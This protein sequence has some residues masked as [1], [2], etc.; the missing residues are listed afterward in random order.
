MNSSMQNR[1]KVQAKNRQSWIRAML[2]ALFALTLAT[3]GAQAT[4]ISKTNNTAGSADGG[5]IT[6][7]VTIEASDF[8][9]NSII[10]DV[11]VAVS[12]EKINGACPTHTDG[13]A[14]NNEI[15]FY[16]E[17]PTGTQ[18]VLV[19]DYL[20][21]AGSGNGATYTEHEYSGPVAVTFN[22]E[23]ALGI[24]SETP[25]SGSFKP[26]QLLS[27]FDDEDPVGDWTLYVGDGVP[28][29][30]LCFQ[31]FTLT[32]SAVQ[33]PVM[34]D[35][36]FDVV[37]HSPNGA[38]VGT[39]VVTDDD[40]GEK[41]NFVI[42]SGND[43][44]IFAINA[45]SGEITV[46]DGSQLDFETPPDS[47][48]LNVRVTD[49]HGLTDTAVITINVTNQNEAPVAVDDSYSADEDSILNVDPDGVL[50][51]DSDPDDDD[52]LMAISANLDSDQG[53]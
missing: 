6:R 40:P 7:T 17:S 36:S 3:L 35:Q 32:V 37:E 9:V 49:S 18:V 30:P 21:S 48:G 52:T 50:D 42:F 31:E 20:N 51:N 26:E 14:Y 22:D 33:A 15:Y 44:D 29:D 23:A 1:K 39:V 13:D 53:A 25:V 5:V 27:A 34:D 46:A 19:E 2:L 12:F 11:N 28:S 41:L 38:S 4:T 43:A 24:K 45:L 47:Y 8:A 16:L 10:R